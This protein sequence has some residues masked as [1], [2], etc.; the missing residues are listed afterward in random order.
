MSAILMK[1][2][3]DL[4][5]TNQAISPGLERIVRHCLEKS[6][7]ERFH[8]A[9]DVAFDLETLSSIS[10]PAARPS[11]FPAARK[12]GLWPAAVV[13]VLLAAA[14][15]A[16]LAGRKSGLRSPPDFSQLTFRRGFISG[17]R[18]GPDGNTLVYSAAW[19][20][21]PP[22]LFTG[23]PGSAEAT[24][25]PADDALL[26]AVSSSGEMALLLH[27][28]NS[29]FYWIGTLAQAP[30][31]GGTPRELLEGVEWADWSPD[32][33]SLAIVRHFGGKERL[34][35]PIG[36]S[37][38][39]TAGFITHPRISSRGDLVAFLDHP[40]EG[41]DGGFVAVVD[42]SGKKKTLSGHWNSALGLS[43]APGGRDIWFTATRTGGN[44]S[45]HAVSPDGRERLLTK[46][47][48][49]L[50]LQDVASDGR[51][52][53]NRDLARL[54]IL[55]LA[56]GDTKERDLSWLDWSLV[57]DFS[58]DGKMLLFDES[59]QGGG[60]NY[61]VYI[62]KTDGSPA[63]RLGDGAAF[64]LS[65]DGRWVA[66][67]PPGP[68]PRPIVLLPTGP[69][70]PRRLAGDQ[71]SHYW[72]RFFPD[73]RRVLFSG[74]VA[75]RGTRLWV[76]DLAGGPPR[77]VS[78]EGVRG[79][80]ITVSPDGK[81]VC[82]PGQDRRPWLYPVDGGQPVLVAGLAAGEAVTQWSPDGRFLYARDIGSL[83]ARIF[84]IERATGRRELWKELMPSDPAGV[85]AIFGAQASADGR[86]YA[87]TYARDLSD[88]FLVEGV[89]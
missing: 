65:P 7:E 42:G 80:P 74:N 21:K 60:P 58:A 38:Y 76:Q 48:G 46:A 2:P 16:Y 83:P 56:P 53:L 26:L 89:R 31:A 75:G 15:V 52:L 44:R 69:G 71:I 35:F 22:Q 13:L 84:R 72:V 37:L 81:F 24:A 77:P 14:G 64:A 82:S 41:D 57:R 50:T 25:L 45:L 62:R 70:E 20:G 59:G 4:S 63:V 79:Y 29:G 33:R 43:W 6:P 34:E 1:E 51:A 11:V 17:A 30:L 28:K 36:K 88:L 87:Y 23:R 68:P 3:P 61:S 55:A 49:I 73:G 12:R 40:I 78:P 47:P 5:V 9:H 85:L 10:A 86:S 8:S 18:F 27:P 19:D 67:S 39:E 66:S 32:G 54:G